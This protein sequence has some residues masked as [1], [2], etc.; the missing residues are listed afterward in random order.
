MI[1]LYSKCADDRDWRFRQLQG[2]TPLSAEPLKDISETL[3]KG[4]TRFS[5]G[6]PS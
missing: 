5:G 3:L 4:F 2:T 6:S 1:E